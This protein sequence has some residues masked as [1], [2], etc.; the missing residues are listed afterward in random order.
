MN[1]E[2]EHPTV[3]SEN[4]ALSAE[5][6]QPSTNPEPDA[7]EEDIIS[8]PVEMD[9]HPSGTP[10]RDVPP[11]AAGFEETSQPMETK[12]YITVH[13]KVPEILAMW[14]ESRQEVIVVYLFESRI[15]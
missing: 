9:H 10:D 3:Q 2:E 1:F 14:Y 6:P 8:E 13:R 7:T 5:V 15:Y 4:S 12:S 11:L